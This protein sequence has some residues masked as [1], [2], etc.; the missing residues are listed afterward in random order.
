MSKITITDDAGNSQDIALPAGITV[1]VAPPVPVSPPP[2]PTAPTVKSMTL[3]LAKPGD[4]H[5]GDSFSVAAALI[6]SDGSAQPSGYAFSGY[7]K[8]ILSSPNN[9]TRTFAALKAGTTTIVNSNSGVRA[10]MEITVLPAAS[11]TPP[12]D[13]APSG[14]PPSQPQPTSPPRGSTGALSLKGKFQDGTTIGLSLDAGERVPM[15]SDLTRGSIV[16]H[17][18]GK[19]ACIENAYMGLLADLTGHFTLTGPEG[20]LCDSDLT[21]WKY[22]RTR[23]FWLAPLVAN[24]NADLSKFPLLDPKAGKQASMLAA[25]QNGTRTDPMDHWPLSAGIGQPGEHGWIGDLTQWAACYLAN[26]S[27]ANAMVM[28]YADAACCAH[29][30]HAIDPATQKMVDISANPNISMLGQLAG[31]GENPFVAGQHSASPLNLEGAYTHAPTWLALSCAVFGADFFR[32][33][34][35]LWANYVGGLWENWAYRMPQGC[36]SARGA[37]RGIGRTLNVLEY[38]SIYSDNPAYFDRWVKALSGNLSQRLIAQ[39]GIAIDQAGAA[40]EGYPN[41]AFAPYQESALIKAVGLLLDH[42]RTELQP[43]FDVLAPLFDQMMTQ[44]QP[45]LAVVYNACWK[46]ASGNIAPDWLTSLQWQ[47]QHSAG[48]RAA[49]QCPAGSQALQLAMSSTNP[50]KAGGFIG[51]DDPSN[52][53]N[54]PAQMQGAAAKVADHWSDRTRA[55]QVWATFQAVAAINPIDY[56]QNPKYAQVPRAA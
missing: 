25:Y 50:Q 26:P 22:A 46:N 33:E 34:L 54:Y 55:A 17:G 45:E 5:V 6:M 47:A 28:A 15:G 39:S 9:W 8:S 21:I 35:S 7:D 56:S 14:P 52:P 27:A 11:A 12:I 1:A 36:I 2:Q 42:R 18:D 20:P 3:E 19:S 13:P 31:Q 23:P 40:Y 4:I 43:A 30:F 37:S 53:E 10:E 41:G 16:C 49:L 44:A 48:L 51:P 32:E 29:G 38:A 24:S